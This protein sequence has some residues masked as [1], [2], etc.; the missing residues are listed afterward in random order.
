MFQRSGIQ[1]V[2]IAM[3]I[4]GLSNQ[5]WPQSRRT[6]AANPGSF[7]ERAI[8]MNRAVVRLADLATTRAESPRV[9]EFAEGT[10]H[11]HMHAVLTLEGSVA[12]ASTAN[13]SAASTEINRFVLTTE[14]QDELNRLSGFSGSDF[15]REFIDALMTEYQRAI[16]LCQQEAGIAG[17]RQKLRHAPPPIAGDQA[18][19][20]LDL[21]PTLQQG[22]LQLEEIRRQLQ[23]GR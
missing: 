16:K 12:S 8:E 2:F 22:L 18:A 5:A 19:F 17:P 10:L 7:L 1:F 3:T 11:R 15:D 6:E 13:A 20:A 4:V 21:L 9:S 14:H 23:S